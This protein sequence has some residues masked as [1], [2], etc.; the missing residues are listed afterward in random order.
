MSTLVDEVVLAAQYPAIFML[1]VGYAV[2]SVSVVIPTYNR[3]DSLLRAINS[4]LR[5][6]VPVLEVLIC[7][8]GSTDA[9][10]EAVLGLNNPIVK[11]LDCGRNG[12]PAIPRNK[13]ILA[14][15]GEWVAFLDSD[16]VWLPEKIEK[17]LG[18]MLTQR[19]LASS[20]NAF[21]VM[22]TGARSGVYIKLDRD[23]ITFDDLIVS[24]WVICSSAIVSRTILQSAGGF[25]ESELL[26]AAEDYALWLRIS[27]HTNF[28]YVA[29]CLMEYTDDSAHSIR[30]DAVEAVQRERVMRD[31]WA[32]GQENRSL[33]GV[34]RSNI[35]SQRYRI[36]MRQNGRTL[37]EILVPR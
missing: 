22:P 5:Q 32:Y 24:N 28:A 10:K 15:T 31:F 20:S 17:Q 23:R 3:K 25:P 26:R 11:W 1:Y 9:S 27:L 18:V 19:C 6:T 34:V 29:E 35:I 13:G 36:A 4:V 21:R 2:A 16:D 12:R 7:D 33:V 37:R 8:D 14:A 30:A